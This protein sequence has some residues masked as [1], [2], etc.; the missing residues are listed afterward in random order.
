MSAPATKWWQEPARPE[1]PQRM[2]RDP[3]PGRGPE[4]VAAPGQVPR[5]LMAHGLHEAL[6]G[7]KTTTPHPLDGRLEQCHGC[8]SWLVAIPDAMRRRW[9]Q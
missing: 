3:E 6:C 7:F 4:M 2:P 5:P 8:R 9:G 1:M